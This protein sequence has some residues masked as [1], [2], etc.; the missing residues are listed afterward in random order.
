MSGIMMSQ[1]IENLQ[2]DQSID[3]AMSPETASLSAAQSSSYRPQH[4]YNKN[5]N[6]TINEVITNFVLADKYNNMHDDDQL[7]INAKLYFE[8]KFEA[9]KLLQSFYVQTFNC[10]MST[11]LHYK[12]FDDQTALP[13]DECVHYVI[14]QARDVVRV[15]KMM[16]VL[17][18]FRYNMYIFLPYCRQLKLILACFVND[19][20]CKTVVRAQIDALNEIIDNA[21]QLLRLV[22]TLNNRLKVMMV[23]AE[24]KLYECHIC[25]ETSMEQHFLKPN[26]CCGFN[27]CGLCYAQLWQHCKLYPV[28]PVCKTS[29]KTV[30]DSPLVETETVD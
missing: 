13:T 25:R 15:L 3:V 26:E 17:P 9:F 10:D 23:F 24:P 4:Y 5:S 12:E 1:Q 14:S 7:P 16:S 6:E 30:S 20:C 27:I 19:Y 8:I 22:K 28:C 29:F 2:H 21:T 18:R 11:L